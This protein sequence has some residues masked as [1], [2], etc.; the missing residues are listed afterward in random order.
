MQKIVVKASQN[1]TDDANQDYGDDVDRLVF[2]SNITHIKY[3]QPSFTEKPTFS[4]TADFN[5]SS[6]DHRYHCCAEESSPEERAPPPCRYLFKRK[7]DATHWSSESRTN[8]RR[9]T[10]RDDIPPV[11]IVVEISQPAP[12][13]T[14]IV[15]TS[16][17]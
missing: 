12:F 17:A 6:E 4:C 2:D 7:Q 15:R 9:S 5:E 16:L 13:E 8:T 11:P 10:T 14:V 3:Y 1:S